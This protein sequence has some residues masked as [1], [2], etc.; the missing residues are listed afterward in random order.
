MIFS[1]TPWESLNRHS[2]LINKPYKKGLRKTITYKFFSNEKPLSLIATLSNLTFLNFR[3]PQKTY[4]EKHFKRD[5]NY[6]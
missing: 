3:P 1:S 5:P 2:R 4:G 6:F